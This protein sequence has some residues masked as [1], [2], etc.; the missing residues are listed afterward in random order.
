MYQDE[1]KNVPADGEVLEAETD[2][3]DET[4]WNKNK[5]VW[6]VQNEHLHK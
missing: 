2:N 5:I 3:L 4:F 6:N 1:I